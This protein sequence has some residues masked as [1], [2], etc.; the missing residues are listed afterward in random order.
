MYWICFRSAYILAVRSVSSSIIMLGSSS[1]RCLS[2]SKQFYSCINQLNIPKSRHVLCLTPQNSITSVRKTSSVPEKSES[3]TLPIFV[4]FGKDIK[5]IY[6]FPRIVYCNWIVN[7]KW[8]II[9]ALCYCAV[10]LDESAFEGS[11]DTESFNF[12]S[13]AFGVVILKSV[14]WGLPFRNFVAHIYITPE[15]DVVLSYLNFYGSRVDEKFPKG[16]LSL[17]SRE[18]G[19]FRFITRDYHYMLIISKST[20][21]IFRIN[22]KYGIMFDEDLFRST[23][24]FIPDSAVDWEAIVDSFVVGLLFSIM[25]Y[26]SI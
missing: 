22:F 9:P 17:Q 8:Y 18:T 25:M 4:K 16:D 15:E 13:I 6:R 19:P 20:R 5:N 3:E 11:L 21:Q 2:I 1:H 7:L 10:A 26:F 14:L 24:G 23:I 12:Y